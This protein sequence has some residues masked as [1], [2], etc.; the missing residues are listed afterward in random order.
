MKYL[1]Y[2]LKHLRRNWIRTLSTIFAMALCIFLIGTLQT[3]LRAFYGNIDRTSTERLV[4]RNRVSL[5]FSLPLSY[6]PRIAAM[7]GVKRVAKV[8]LVRRRRADSDRRARHEELL[9]EL[10]GRCG[11]VPRDVPGVRADRAEE[12]AFFGDGAA[13]SSAR[14]SPRSSAGRSGDTF[15]L[16]STIPPYRVGQA[17][18][19][20]SCAAIYRRRHAQYPSHSEQLMLF[21]WKYLYEIDAASARRSGTYN[22][23]IANPARRPR[24]PRPSTR[25]SRTATRRR[26]PRPKASSS[27][28]SSR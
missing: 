8:E 21:H 24:W 20:S 23:Q 22:V 16:E 4:T 10:R 28:G 13:R 11:A 26:R 5:V 6:E 25:P 18:S 3:L 27:P 9:P 12:K 15:Q 17:R 19:S 7:P 1:P 2:I 14:G